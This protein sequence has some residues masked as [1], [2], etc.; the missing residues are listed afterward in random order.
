M[1]HEP[2][3]IKRVPPEHERRGILEFVRAAPLL[4]CREGLQRLVVLP[5]REVRRQLLAGQLLPLLAAILA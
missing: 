1:V 2:C 5:A 4:K 3:T